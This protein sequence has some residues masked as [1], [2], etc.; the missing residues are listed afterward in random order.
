[1]P[2]VGG[3][4]T[5]NDAGTFDYQAP[6]LGGAFGLFPSRLYK[7]V[8]PAPT[9]LTVTVSWPTGQDLGVYYFAADG[10]TEPA[11]G[12][13]ADNGG[14]GATPESSTSALL[15]GTYLLAVVNFGTGDP[16]VFSLTI[17]R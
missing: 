13:P 2:G 15:P 3:S 6:I 4:T 5:I 10:T 11:E 9:T 8:V 17:S 1:M 16:P 14:A 7:I 12:V